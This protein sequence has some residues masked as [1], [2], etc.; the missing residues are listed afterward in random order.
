MTEMGKIALESQT[1]YRLATI[2]NAWKDHD[3][4]FKF[5]V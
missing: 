1:T 3:S 5:K 2:E 4:Q